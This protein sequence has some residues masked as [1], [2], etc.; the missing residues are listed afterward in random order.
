MT[1]TPNRCN[2]IVDRERVPTRY[3]RTRKM[4]KITT[5]FVSLAD[6]EFH[7]NHGSY[8]DSMWEEGSVWNSDYL[9][10]HVENI[11][12]SK[13][14]AEKE[15]ATFGNTEMRDYGS[16][17]SIEEYAIIE[18]V[19]D[20]SKI[21]EDYEDEITNVDEFIS[22]LK[23]NPFDFGEYEI[24]EESEDI[25]S[26]SPRKF[27]V[28]VRHEDHTEEKVF[29]SYKDAEDYYNEMIDKIDDINDVELS[30]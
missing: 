11:F 5:Y 6:Y 24:Y 18:R 3:K 14:D 27:T 15:L 20:L 30:Y 12:T 2:I 9:D 16:Y 28:E 23:N 13:E 4:K 19:Y 22:A 29:T 21:Y 25:W 17:F 8:P 7:K 10:E 1:Y 26:F